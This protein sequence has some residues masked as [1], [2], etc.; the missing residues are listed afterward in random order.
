[1]TNIISADAIKRARS[2]VKKNCLFTNWSGDVRNVAAPE[3]VS[4]DKAVDY[5]LISST[6]QLDLYKN[7][8]CKNLK[9]WQIGYDPKVMYPKFN[10]QFKYD[11]VFAGNAYP[12]DTFADARKRH[13]ILLALKTHFKDRF[14]IFG[15]GYAPRFG[16]TR[17]LSPNEVCEVYNNSVCVLSISN[18]NDVA[19]YFSDRLLG[20]L[21][22]GR[23]T[24]S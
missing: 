17:G 4:V 8:G 12:F 13:D 20:C 14:G 16:H 23:P 5:T 21:A 19:H 1:M 11:L 15:S 9:Y 2:K 10:T 7:A 18:Y 24:V 3:I 6:G 22:S